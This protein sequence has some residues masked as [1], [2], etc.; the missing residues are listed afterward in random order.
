MPRKFVVCAAAAVL[1]VLAFWLWPRPKINLLLI[2]L[3]TTRADRVGCYGYRR[4]K[5]P[6]LDGLAATGVLCERAYTV[7]PLTLPAHASLLTGLYPAE[8]G[9]RSNGRGRLDDSIP[10]LAEILK[11]QGYDTA[12]FVASFVLDARFGLARGFKT[13]DD[14]IGDETPDGE[15]L[16]RERDG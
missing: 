14:E 13:Y 3:D 16:H 5:T 4:A 7:A 6:V 1:G 2:T 15:S 8:H 9:V 10:T 11:R 12:A